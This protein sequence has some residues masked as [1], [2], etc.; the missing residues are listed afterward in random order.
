MMSAAKKYF[1]LFLMCL[2]FVV[3]FIHAHA[4][5]HDGSKAQIF[6]VHTDETGIAN[7]ENSSFSQAQL[8]NHEIIGAITTVSSGIST[9]DSDDIADDIA[10]IATLFVFGLMIFNITTK[11]ARPLSLFL[12]SQNLSYS[13]QNPRAPPR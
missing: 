10:I 13:L 6:H 4:F 12:P 2:Q 7:A 9:S 8:H 3:P 11:F 5:G 1:F